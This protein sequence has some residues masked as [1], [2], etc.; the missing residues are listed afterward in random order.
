MVKRPKRPEPCVNH[1]PPSS[2]EVKEKRAVLL[3]LLWA[4]VV[5]YWATLSFTFLYLNLIYFYEFWRIRLIHGCCSVSVKKYT[6]LPTYAIF[7]F[8]KVRSK[9]KFAQVGI[10]RACDHLC[11]WSAAAWRPRPLCYRPAVFFR[12]L[13]RITF[14]FPQGNNRRAF[15]NRYYFNSFTFLKFPMS[16]NVCNLLRL[17]RGLRVSVGPYGLYTVTTW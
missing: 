15:Q 12:P 13:N 14:L 10:E 8:R 9:W 2:D 16:G 7:S 17:G 11:V 3:L 6:H 1:P 5:C 4:F